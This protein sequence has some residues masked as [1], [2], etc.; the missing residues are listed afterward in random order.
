MKTSMAKE[1]EDKGASGSDDEIIG[2]RQQPGKIPFSRPG[3]G[4]KNRFSQTADPE[5]IPS[6]QGG[7]LEQPWG[8]DRHDV[9]VSGQIIG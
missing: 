8:P 6:S 4:G 9:L 3:S 2:Y 1:E 7:S 5:M